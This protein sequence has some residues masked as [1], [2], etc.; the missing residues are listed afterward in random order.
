MAVAKK[1]RMRP[2]L[3]KEQRLV[4]EKAIIRDLEGGQM[5][6]RQIAAKHKVSLP[7]VNSKARKAGISRRAST[8]V[9]AAVARKGPARGRRGGRRAAP[10]AAG[11]MAVPVRRAGFNEQFRNLVMAYYPNMSLAKF[12]QLNSMI[13]RAVA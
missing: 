7:T 8:R 10:Q 6:Y 11:R 9:A 5:T 3:S 13:R 12:E 4:R 2:S 1:R